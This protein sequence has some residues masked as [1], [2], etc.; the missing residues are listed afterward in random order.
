VHPARITLDED[1]YVLIRPEGQWDAPGILEL[2]VGRGAA[3]QPH[4]G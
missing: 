2:S 1:P 3:A 4:A